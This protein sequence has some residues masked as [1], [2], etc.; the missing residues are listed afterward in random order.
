MGVSKDRILIKLAG[1]WEGIQAVKIL[2]A[3]GIQC[4]ITLV[5][6][7]LQTIA[8]AQTGTYSSVPS[9]DR[10]STGTKSKAARR[11]TPPTPIPDSSP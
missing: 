7:F 5:F 1:T 2:E 4:N 3:E 9:R 8:A 11:D 10:Y 6:N